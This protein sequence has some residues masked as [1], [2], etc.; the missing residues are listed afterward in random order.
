[1]STF[2]SMLLA[3]AMVAGLG[4]AADAAIQLR[5]SVSTDGGAFVNIGSADDLATP[6]AAVGVFSGLGIDVVIQTAIGDP[7]Q[8]YP[9]FSTTFNATNSNDAGQRTLLLE[10]TQTGVPAASLNQ[11]LSD[12]SIVNL[13][14]TTGATITSYIDDGDTPFATTTQLF[15]NLF[16]ASGQAASADGF[17]AS[18]TYSQTIT[19]AIDYLAAT[20]GTVGGAAQLVAV[21]PEPASLALLGAGLLG[22]GFAARRRRTV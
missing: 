14:N 19:V 3:G 17:P 11:L 12:F 9:G 6:G 18:G 16:L 10:F 1:M 13:L 21:V 5:A 2:R 7:I 15:S 22:L 8:P 4:S 20:A